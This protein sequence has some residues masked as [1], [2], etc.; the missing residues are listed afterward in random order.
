MDDDD[1]M[2]RWFCWTCALACFTGTLFAVAKDAAL[3]AWIL[4]ALTAVWLRAAYLARPD[5]HDDDWRI[6]R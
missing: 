2:P 5:V 4:G 3:S 1:R 6:S